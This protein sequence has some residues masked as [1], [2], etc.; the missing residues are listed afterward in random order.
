MELEI[1]RGGGCGV[2]NNYQQQLQSHKRRTVSA[3]GVLLCTK[4]ACVHKEGLF[5]LVRAEVDYTSREAFG[6]RVTRI[7]YSRQYIEQKYIWFIMCKNGLYIE[8]RVV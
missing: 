3:V 5:R 2:L 1:W 8:E 6:V 4:I 7:V